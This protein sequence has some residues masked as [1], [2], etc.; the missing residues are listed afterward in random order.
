MKKTILAI[1]AAMLILSIIISAC[2][3]SHIQSINVVHGTSEISDENQQATSVETTEDGEKPQ[4]GEETSISHNQDCN[5]DGKEENENMQNGTS[6]N[7]SE[8]PADTSQDENTC[9]NVCPPDGCIYWTTQ[10]PPYAY[11]PTWTPKEWQEIPIVPPK[12]EN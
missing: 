10:E 7:P 5:L 2:L 4:D 8:N 9:T 3:V 12:P 6:N 11:T 1:T